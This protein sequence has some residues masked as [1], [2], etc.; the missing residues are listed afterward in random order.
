MKKYNSYA[1]AKIDNPDCEIYKLLPRDITK[2]Y[3]YFASERDMHGKLLCTGSTFR[4]NP[5]EH[6]MTL[7]QFFDAGHKLVDGD[8]YLDSRGDVCVVGVVIAASKVNARN[9]NDNKRYIL[10]AKALE[11]KLKSEWANGDECVINRKSKARWMVVGVNPLRGSVV[12]V[13]DSG[14]LKDFHEWQLKKTRITNR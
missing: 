9:V 4:C 1:E 6:C 5:A 3:S 8:T 13:S 10:R 2:E 12:C 14:E 7:E 11:P